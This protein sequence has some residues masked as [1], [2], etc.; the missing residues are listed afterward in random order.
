MLI[1]CRMPDILTARAV[2]YALASLQRLDVLNR[3]IVMVDNRIQQAAGKVLGAIWSQD[4]YEKRY[5]ILHG[6][7][8]RICSGRRGKESS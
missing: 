5:F 4:A 7:D 1:D 2:V 8:L 6:G 3:E